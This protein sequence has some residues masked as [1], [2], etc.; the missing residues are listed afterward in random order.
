MSCGGS[1]HE[2]RNALFISMVAEDCQIKT[3]TTAHLFHALI[4]KARDKYKMQGE[5]AHA[6]ARKNLYEA[7][8]REYRRLKAKSSGGWGTWQWERT[9]DEES[10]TWSVKPLKPKGE[11]PGVDWRD[12]Y[13]DQ[14][15]AEGKALRVR[16]GDD[17][18]SGEGYLFT[19]DGR[20]I[21]GL[22][23]A[24]GVLF[25]TELEDGRKAFFI[26]RRSTSIS[27]GGGKWAFPGGAR[28]K[29]EPDHE[30]AMREFA[31]EIGVLPLGAK[32]AGSLR[33]DVIP[34]E[35]AYTTVVVDVPGR[36]EIPKDGGDGE[37]MGTAWVTE[38]TLKRGVTKGKLHRDFAKALPAL[39]TIEPANQ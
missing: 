28:D 20:R 8:D 31:E 38:D 3:K 9:W 5:E 17:P 34:G 6:F 1:K 37:T 39:L 22:Y 14:A 33:D 15:V 23:G 10:R 11:P 32:V 19:P 26:A 36:F 27:G 4:K 2:N 30:A 7:A 24:S 35:W 16:M 21:W 18:E 12:H 13:R 29:S 25:R